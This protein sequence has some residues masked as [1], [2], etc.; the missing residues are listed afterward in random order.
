MKDINRKVKSLGNSSLL[1]KRV[2]KI[3]QNEAKEQRGMLLGTLRVSLLFNISI[4]K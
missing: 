2:S 3:I 1:L 4:N